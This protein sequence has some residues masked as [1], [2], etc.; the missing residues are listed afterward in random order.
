M[1]WIVVCLASKMF[2]VFCTLEC[3]LHFDRSRFL[4]S[5]MKL[6]IACMFW[7]ARFLHVFTVFSFVTLHFLPF[8]LRC[9]VHFDIFMYFIWLRTQY[10]EIQEYCLFSYVSKLFFESIAYVLL[11]EITMILCSLNK[12]TLGEYSVVFGL[13]TVPFPWIL[14][15]RAFAHLGLRCSF[16]RSMFLLS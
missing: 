13:E 2:G 6:W 10:P 14:Q 11:S 15:K 1:F 3:L 9:C 5:R 12:L 7:A 16:G 8:L 4:S